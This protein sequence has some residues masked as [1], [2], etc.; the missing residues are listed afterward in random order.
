MPYPFTPCGRATPETALQPYGFRTGLP[1]A[2]FYPF[3][4]PTPYAVAYS[5]VDQVMSH[6]DS[7]LN[8]GTM[9]M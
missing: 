7:F 9:K 1:A 2:I 5:H 4:H 8:E 6:H 3:E